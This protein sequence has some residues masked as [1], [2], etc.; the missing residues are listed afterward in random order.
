MLWLYLHLPNLLLEHYQQAEAEPLPLALVQGRPPRIIAA[1]ALAA[2]AGVA[3]GQTLGTA[4]CLQPDLAVMPA[5]EALQTQVLEQL[6]AWTYQYAAQLRPWLPD[7]LLLEAQSVTRLHGGLPPLVRHLRQGLHAQGF[8]VAMAAGTNPLMARTLARGHADTLIQAPFQEKGRTN[9]C[10]DDQ[11]H[12]H[13]ALNRLPVS[14]LGLPQKSCER[15]LRMGITRS[16]GLFALPD[17]QLAQRLGPELVE[18]LQQLRQPGKD[19]LPAWQP[20]AVFQQRLDL[21]QEAERMAGLFFPLQRLL[22]NLAA[23][24]QLRQQCTDTLLLRLQHREAT[25]TT[26]QVRT[27]TVDYREERF[28]ELCRLHLEQH[29]LTAPVIALSLTVERFQARDTQAQ[30]LFGSTASREEQ[31][32]E[33]LGRLEAKLGNGQVARLA[34]QADHRPEHAWRYLSLQQRRTPPVAEI[35][36]RPLWLLAAP[37]PL[38]ETPEAWLG[39]PER[40]QAGWWDGQRLQRDYY[41]ARL[42]SQSLAWLFRSSDGSWFVH[43]WF[44]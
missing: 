18:H 37:L 1:N 16:D 4:T 13:H 42:S 3:P 9:L 26:I 12:L 41:I 14:A 40:I 39:G 22:Q 2:E 27:T 25:A 30:D 23:Y 38:R 21:V 6:C 29:A 33:L 8:T 43:G 17:R 32:Q 15:L 10:T 36:R 28:M 44:A 31:L 11:E 34:A 20:P 5:D 7:G 35:P 24:L 19:R